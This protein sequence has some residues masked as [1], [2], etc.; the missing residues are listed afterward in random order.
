MT[1]C[2]DS[3]LVADN[4]AFVALPSRNN[5]LKLIFTR[6]AC[7]EVVRPISGGLTSTEKDAIDDNV[8]TAVGLP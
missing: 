3:A 4:E 5:G 6:T 2:Y 7:N 8:L 1:P